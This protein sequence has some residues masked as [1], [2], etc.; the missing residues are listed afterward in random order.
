MIRVFIAD[1]FQLLT[2]DLA[3]V[4]NAQK[5][6]CVAGTAGSGRETYEKLQ[7]LECDIALID[8]EME[9]MNTG[10]LVAE[11]IREVKPKLKVIFLTAHETEQIVITA[12][13]AGAVD[14]IVKGVPDEGI[15]LHIRAAYDD[16]S[17]LDSKIQK[18]IMGEYTRA[19][20]SEQSLLYFINNLSALTNTERELVKLLLEG[21]KVA[22][23]AK[24]R[25]VELVTVKTQIK[26]LLRK[27]RCSRTK[28]IVKMIHELNLEHLF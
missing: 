24:I 25:C 6:M 20:R 17:L 18:I 2:E 9:E 10:I 4:I 12:M 27:F 5:D 13:G 8:I 15:L 3:E 28:E 14:Y 7:D 26:G 22:E 11:K 23:I 1:D 16:K 19:R 21:R